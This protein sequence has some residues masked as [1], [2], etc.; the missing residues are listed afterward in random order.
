MKILYFTRT[1]QLLT[2]SGTYRDIVL[3]EMTRRHTIKIFSSAED[4]EED[5]DIA[6]IL[7]LKH[8]H[9][10]NLQKLGCPV[11]V[12]IHDYYW[13]QFY[14][15]QCPD[16]PLRFM[17]QKVRKWRYSN[18]LKRAQAIIVH[19]EYMNKKIPH[20]N[21]FLI[22]L[23]IN[24]NDYLGSPVQRDKNLIL[25]IGRD[26]FRKGL[27]TLIRAL[28]LVL[29]EI[30][31]ARV[32]VIGPEPLHSRLAAKFLSRNL[33]IEFINGLSQKDIK[34]YLYRA[35]VFVLPSEIEA[36]GIVLLEAMAAGLPIVATDVGGIPEVINHGINGLLVER[37]DSE[38][39]AASIVT[40]LRNDK[41][42]KFDDMK[43][44][45]IW[46][47]LFNPT[48]MVDSIDSAYQ[49][50]TRNLHTAKITAN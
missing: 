15:F 27:L 7:D 11:I 39:L 13:T 42:E 22:R 47:D 50:I 38:Q 41:I 3:A 9:L 48:K 10:K 21:I 44:H 20:S 25:F 40:Y 32:I 23:A 43:N 6:H 2:G 37:G 33:P 16:L 14:P 29:K 35:N 18:I 1:G 31:G 34:E 45:P 30:P 24:P 5:W 8:A 4:Y 12:D 26:Y 28:P 49:Q 19:S 17:L 36:S 46:G